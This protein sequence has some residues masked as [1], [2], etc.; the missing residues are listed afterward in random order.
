M[1]HN[2]T[3]S[4][5]H[6]LTGLHKRHL[7]GALF[8]LDWCFYDAEEWGCSINVICTPPK[9]DKFL[10][11]GFDFF[12]KEDDKI[13]TLRKNSSKGLTKNEPFGFIFQRVLTKI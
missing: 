1:L 12:I 8:I 11:G 4:T 3:Y 2:I 5:F 10:N 13:L 7:F 6:L 9:D